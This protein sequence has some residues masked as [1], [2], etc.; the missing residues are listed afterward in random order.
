MS[1]LFVPLRCVQRH[2][3]IKILMGSSQ[4]GKRRSE[5]EGQRKCYIPCD[6]SKKRQN[7]SHK[8]IK[9]QHKKGEQY[10][11]NINIKSVFIII[12]QI[13]IGLS[14]DLFGKQLKISII[15][16]HKTLQVLLEIYLLGFI[17]M[18]GIRSNRSLG[19]CSAS[20]PL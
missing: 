9:T 3:R 1:N 4:L 19:Y 13:L 16:L 2:F 7:N 5:G 20:N 8:I 12:E 15:M 10:I 14:R 6:K 17:H 18:M 11:S